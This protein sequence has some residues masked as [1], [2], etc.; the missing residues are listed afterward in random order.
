MKKFS[1]SLFFVALTAPFSLFATGL[2]FQTLNPSV[3]DVLTST[4]SEID[5]SSSVRFGTLTGNVDY[6]T[7]IG[8]YSTYADFNTAFTSLVTASV[9]ESTPN[10]LTASASAG[11]LSASLN[12]WVLIDT[13]S[14]Q[15]VFYSGVTPGLGQLVVTPQLIA[16]GTGSANVAIGSFS[17]NNMLT[18][19]PVPEPATYAALAGLC[20]LGAVMVRRRRA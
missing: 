20:A 3:G 9:I 18:A 5:L 4:S 10:N 14:E 13:G 19:V 12:L 6:A 17:G 15:G 8:S 7:G 1:F 2:S 16:A 11:D